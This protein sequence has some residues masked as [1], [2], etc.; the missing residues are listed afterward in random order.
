M[1]REIWQAIKNKC[2]ISLRI[3]VYRKPASHSVTII[4]LGRVLT[5]DFPILNESI[6]VTRALENKD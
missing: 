1:T 3:G 4:E 5:N 6:F 2:T